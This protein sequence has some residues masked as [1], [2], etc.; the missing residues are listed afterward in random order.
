MAKRTTVVIHDDLDQSEGAS[1][2]KFGL[3][4]KEYEIDLSEKH[5][6]ELRDA[7]KKFLDAATKV[8]SASSAPQR[9]K[10]GTGPARKDTSHIRKWLREEGIDISD[11]G[12]IPIDLMQQ[13]QKYGAN[14]QSIPGRQAPAQR[15]TPDLSK[16]FQPPQAAVVATGNGEKA[17]VTAVA[18]GKPTEASTPRPAKKAAAKAQ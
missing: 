5:E 12:R 3:D 1:T 17:T 14:G 11:R 9:R 6:K 8:G 18:P 7:L 10:Y 15:N 4:G 13:W 2:I 16:P